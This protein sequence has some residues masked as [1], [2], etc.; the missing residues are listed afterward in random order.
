LV[1]LEEPCEVG[2]CT[3][4]AGSHAFASSPV[5]SSHRCLPR[6]CFRISYLIFG[7]APRLCTLEHCLLCDPTQA[8]RHPY[9]HRHH[10]PLRSFRAYAGLLAETPSHQ[11]PTSFRSIERPSLVVFDDDGS[12]VVSHRLCY[13]ELG[14]KKRWVAHGHL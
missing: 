2:D 9:A 10:L 4:R 8:C 3:A 13:I 12:G 11:T 1:E 6:A 14:H 7:L 5:R